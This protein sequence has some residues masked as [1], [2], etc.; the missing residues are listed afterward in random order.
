MEGQYPTP[1]I[2]AK[3]E[4]FAK[5]VLMPGDPL[6]SKFIAETY[7]D[8]AKLVNNIRG[9]QGY[10]GY[11]KGKR[12]SVMASGM[13]IPSMGIYSYE[14]FNIFGVDNIIRIG[15]TGTIDPDVK[16]MDLVFAMGSSTTSNFA[17]IYELGEGAHFSATASFRI[18]D[19]AVRVARNTKDLNFHVGNVLSYDAF[20]CPDTNLTEKWSKLGIMCYEMESYALYCNAARAKKNA[21]AM[22]TVSDDCL[23]GYQLPAEER[24]TAFRKMMEVALET[25][26]TL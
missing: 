7:L 20:Y 18:L 5:T 10:T 2:N 19:R 23:T 8:D 13:G 6:R 24:Q 25:A 3:P 14:L 9:I 1:H 16:L 21:L 17:S 4:D 11:Y 15:T 22:M 26:V 12:I